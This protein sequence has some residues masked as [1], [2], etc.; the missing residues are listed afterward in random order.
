MKKI[1][2]QSDMGL[3]NLP[4]ES[5]CMLEIDTSELLNS[6]IDSQQYW[7]YAIKAAIPAG[8][9]ALKLLEGKTASWNDII[10]NNNFI[11]LPTHNPLEEET[12]QPK[13]DNKPPTKAKQRKKYSYNLLLEKVKSAKSKAT[14]IRKSKKRKTVRS[15]I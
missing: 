1:E 6:K 15:G 2:R 5:K 3:C 8:S 11:N 10:K 7:L 14:A 13:V 9:R 4:P 12:P